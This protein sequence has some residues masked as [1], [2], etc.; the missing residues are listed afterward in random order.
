MRLLLTISTLSL[1]ALVGCA[2]TIAPVTT[3][4]T[5]Q[6]TEIKRVSGRWI[7][8]LDNRITKTAEEVRPL[9]PA[10]YL[11]TYSVKPGP[12]LATALQHVTQRFFSQ[13][14]FSDDSEPG[15]A[16]SDT[17]VVGVVRVHL[18]QFQAGVTCR[19]G[20]FSQPCL[21][22]VNLAINVEI[23]DR[24]GRV[25][26]NSDNAANRPA[27]GDIGFFCRGVSTVLEDAMNSAIA[28]T[29]ESV[30]SDLRKFASSY[31]Q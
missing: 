26:H 9:G 19:R 31:I 29:V 20:L 3:P 27:D 18:K 15:A 24:N 13:V 7:L 4:A 23:V 1:L 12:A 2:H 30:A 5:T 6:A 21:G 17:A 25:L 14:A 28:G 22:Q 8:H 16:I 10:C 11:D